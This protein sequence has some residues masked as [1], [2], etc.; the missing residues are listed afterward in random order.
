MRGRFPVL[1]DDDR[2]FAAA[3]HD[4]SPVDQTL[5]ARQ[6]PKVPGWVEDPDKWATLDRATRRQ[7]ERHHRKVSGR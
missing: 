7:L 3:S 2:R 4:A 5:Q 1:P 6:L